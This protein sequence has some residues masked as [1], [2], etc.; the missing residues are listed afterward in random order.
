MKTTQDI[1][2]NLNVVSEIVDAV[3]LWLVEVLLVL[4]VS[5][6][7]SVD[8]SNDDVKVFISKQL[9]LGSK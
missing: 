8:G 4:W 5:P 6:F 3:I 2:H 9:V 1:L 7:D